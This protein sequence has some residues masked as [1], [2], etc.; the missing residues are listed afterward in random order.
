MTARHS[1]QPPLY[2]NRMRNPSP[3]APVPARF[4]A[5]TASTTCSTDG[6]DREWTCTTATEAHL[7][8]T[9]REG[10]WLRRN[11]LPHQISGRTRASL[12]L[13]KLLP[14]KSL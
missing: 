10:V 2:E 3:S 9:L 12:A 8:G 1:I 14:N 6:Q 11:H 5:F 7:G 13:L 4:P